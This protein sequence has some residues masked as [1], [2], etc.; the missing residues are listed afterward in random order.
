MKNTDAGIAHHWQGVAVSY[1]TPET[2]SLTLLIL[3]PHLMMVLMRSQG[4]EST[5][6]AQVLVL[7]MTVHRR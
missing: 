4:L 5:W 2:V 7:M 3:C 1:S 6:N